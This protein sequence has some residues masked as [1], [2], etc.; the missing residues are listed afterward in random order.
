MGDTSKIDKV[1]IW[2]SPDDGSSWRYITTIDNPLSTTSYDWWIPYDSSL[3]YPLN[4]KVKVYATNSS[5]DHIAEAITDTFTINPPLTFSFVHPVSSEIWQTDSL[6]RIEWSSTGD[7]SQVRRIKTWF[8]YSKDNGTTW[9]DW[10]WL[11]MYDRDRDG[12]DV[13]ESID[14]YYWKVF[15]AYEDLFSDSDYPVLVQL[16]LYAT[17]YHGHYV[18]TEAIQSEPITV[19]PPL[20]ITVTSPN[21]G[22]YL[23]PGSTYTITWNISGYTG[24]IQYIKI[25][26]STD[27]GNTWKYVKTL[28]DPSITSYD[29]TIP[30]ENSYSCLIKVYATDANGNYLAEDVSDSIFTIGSG[31]KWTVLVYM[32]G[33]NGGTYPLEGAGIDDINEMEQVNLPSDVNVLVQFDRIAGHDSSNGDWT[34]TRR[35]RIIHDNDPNHPEQSSRGNGLLLPRC[36]FRGT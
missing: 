27:S 10:I 34:T 9:S 1:K 25:K 31:A 29:W 4:A 32:D 36:Y 33:D 19:Q 17:D 28:T 16:K 26:Y 7:R 20:K 15:Y 30:D 12:D 24:F 18:T 22:E 8:R 21:G 35:Y 23:T 5:G 13:I 14:H 3:T 6:Q 11:K 2:Y